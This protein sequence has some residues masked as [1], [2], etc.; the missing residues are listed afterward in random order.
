VFEGAKRKEGFNQER[1]REL[2]QTTERLSAE[3]GVPAMVDIVAN[4]G[5]EFQSYI[6][7]V[8]A[9][10]NLPF[11][12]DAW[13][14]K[15]KLQGAAYCAEKGLLDRMFYNS[16]TVWEQDIETEI[17]EIADLGVKHVLLVAFDQEDQMASGR[18]TGTQRLLDAMDK[19]GVLARNVLANTVEGDELRTYAAGLRRLTKHDPVNRSKLHD[20][21][22]DRVIE[23]G[24]WT[25][26]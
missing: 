4:T 9:E 25:V 1:A 2:L 18:V 24:G 22:A 21:I 7:F 23:V 5:Q 17:K 20:R 13:V 19:V 3:S 26:E 11:C 15:P 12:I 6:D 14:M 8:A 10:C 16:L